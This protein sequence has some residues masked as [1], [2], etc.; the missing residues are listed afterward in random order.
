MSVKTNQRPSPLSG[1]RPLRRG[2]LEFTIGR[3]ASPDR[4]A[5]ARKPPNWDWRSPRRCGPLQ[6]LGINYISRPPS[7]R[8]PHVPERFRGPG[9]EEGLVHL[10]RIGRKAAFRCSPTFMNRGRPIPP[11]APWTS[12]RYRPFSAARRTAPRR[13]PPGR[14]LNVKKAQFLA[15]WDMKNVLESAGGRSPFG[16]ALRA[17]DHH[18]YGQL[19]VDMRSFR[20]CAPSGVRGLRRNPQRPDARSGRQRQRRRPEIHLPWP[21]LLLP[22]GGRPF[23]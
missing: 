19:V 2:G 8:P 22:P 5:C 15:P 11:P 21:G 20:S 14:P 4:R 1:G 12:S 6:T 7:T 17:G 13:G 18:G 16:D 9:M 10:A 3:G 23:S